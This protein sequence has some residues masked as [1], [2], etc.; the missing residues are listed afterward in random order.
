MTYMNRH[1]RILEKLKEQ[2]DRKVMTNHLRG[3]YVEYMIAD[4]LGADP[5]GYDW[6]QWDLEFVNKRIEIK[7]SAARQTWHARGKSSNSPRFDIKERTGYYDSESRWFDQPGRP[8][9]LYIFAWHDGEDQRCADQWEFYIIRAI[10]LPHAQK[11]IGLSP[12][13]QMTDMVKSKD[14]ARSVTATIGE[15]H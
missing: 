11:S 1:S 2:Y 9:D 3:S 8:A 12:I 7:Q 13:R 4:I 10:D 6:A 5:V 14:L 15:M